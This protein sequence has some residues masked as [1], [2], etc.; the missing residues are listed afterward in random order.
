[1]GS[2]ALVLVEGALMLG[3][4]LLFFWLLGTVIEWPER[5]IRWLFKKKA[6]PVDPRHHKDFDEPV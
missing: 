4:L 2:A 5:V 3:A 1:M 6:P